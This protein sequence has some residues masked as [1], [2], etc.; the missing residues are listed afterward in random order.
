WCD[1][2]RQIGAALKSLDPVA[3]RAL[4][5]ASQKPL[6]DLVAARNDFI[7]R[8]GAGDDALE[9]ARLVVEGASA[10]LAVPVRVV[11]SPTAYETRVGTPVRAGVWRKTQGE[12]PAGADSG[13]AWLHFTRATETTAT[14]D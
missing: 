7:H 9:R 6:A 12:V 10:V 8:G 5:F 14:R 11:A 2:C 3:A 13:S 4:A 1:L